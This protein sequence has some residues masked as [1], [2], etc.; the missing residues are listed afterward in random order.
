MNLQFNKDWNHY[1]KYW[2]ELKDQDVNVNTYAAIKRLKNK[3]ELGCI[4][5]II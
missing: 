2:H 3:S 1:S 5:F 4:A